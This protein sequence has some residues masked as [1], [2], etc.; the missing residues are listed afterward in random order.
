LLCLLA[1]ASAAQLTNASSLAAPWPDA[2]FSVLRVFG[3]LALVVALFLGGVWCF[4]HW[5]RL[6]VTRGRSPKLKILEVKPLGHRHALYVVAYE[7]QRLLVASSPAGVQLVSP[8]PDADEDEPA[9][10]APS[11][12][13]TLQHAFAPKS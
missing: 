1:T 13:E 12:A 5:Q 2:S 9:S 8:L 7:H 11:F 4:R 10:A 3:A 6:A